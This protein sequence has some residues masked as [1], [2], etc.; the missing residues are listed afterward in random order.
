MNRKKATGLT[1]AAVASIFA[2]IYT[3]KKFRKRPPRPIE[4]AA[5]D[6]EIKEMLRAP[7]WKRFVTEVDGESAGL[8]E[9]EARSLARVKIR[10]YLSDFFSR[11]PDEQVHD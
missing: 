6:S 3:A 10:K 4:K 7:D 5:L 2:V 11:H 8:S 9:D 1:V